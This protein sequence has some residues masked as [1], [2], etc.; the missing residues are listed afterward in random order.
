MVVGKLFAA[1]AVGALLLG[2]GTL[3]VRGDAAATA[4][5]PTLPADVVEVDI[6]ELTSIDWDEGGELPSWVTELD[7]KT[8][9]IQGYMHNSVQDETNRFP[10]VSDVCQCVGRL[11]PHHFI[12]VLLPRETTDPL[13]GS[14]EVMGRFNVGERRDEDGFVTSL[15]RMRGEIF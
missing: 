6:M 11:M 10:F 12:D 8:V 13:P 14:F 7:G 2:G 3:A 9:L 4:G 15:Y 5:A 1:A